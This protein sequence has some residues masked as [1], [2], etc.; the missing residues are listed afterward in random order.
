MTN[1]HNVSLDDLKAF[2][3]VAR[4]RNFRRAAM[5]LSVSPSAISQ[6]VRRLEDQLGIALLNRSTR[7][8]SPTAAGE[9]LSE[10]VLTTFDVVLAAL[11]E[12]TTFK[13]KP[14][15]LVRINAPRPVAHLILAPLI[16]QF[17]RAEPGVSVE[18]TA[19]DALIDIVEQRFDAGVRFGESLRKDVIAAR[20]G[21][22]QRM[23]I[24]AAPSY[25]EAHGHPT[26]IEELMRHNLIRHRFPGGKVFDWELEHQGRTISV[27]PTGTL[28][29][30][31]PHVAI[32]AVLDGAGLSFEFE[33]YA[34][35]AMVQGR[36]VSV[37]QDWCP[38]FPAPY[39]YFPS[40]DNMS[41]A[42]RAFVDFVRAAAVRLP[43]Q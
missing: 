33:G 5:E 2:A 4:H 17:M 13:D 18:L 32:R 10:Q 38:W 12:V 27:T 21:G 28:T 14:T 40:K 1:L 24:L 39:I 11:N 30:N 36:I 41:A 42:V 22:P 20:L 29:V 6:M 9:R 37:M 3:T 16:T 34:S 25:L 15:G 35:E 43:A 7:S 31:D 8:V 23:L 26:S 19:D